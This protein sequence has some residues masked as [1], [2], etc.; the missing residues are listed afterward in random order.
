MGH[1]IVKRVMLT[2]AFHME[3]EKA[4]IIIEVVGGCRG[5]GERKGWCYIFIP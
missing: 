4:R 3:S 2:T 1:F 5:E